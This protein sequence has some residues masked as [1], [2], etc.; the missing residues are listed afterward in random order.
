MGKKS[1]IGRIVTPIVM[2]GFT[3]YG[4]LSGGVSTEHNRGVLEQEWDKAE[5][6]SVDETRVGWMPGQKRPKAMPT[7]DT[8]IDAFLGVRPASEK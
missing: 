1:T 8:F 4:I 7:P 6:V 2:C 5:D 3:A